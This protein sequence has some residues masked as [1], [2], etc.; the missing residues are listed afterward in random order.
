MDIIRDLEFFVISLQPVSETQMTSRK[1][2]DLCQKFYEVGKSYIEEQIRSHPMENVV[3]PGAAHRQGS[4]FNAFD[5]M[6]EFFQAS[7]AYSSTGDEFHHNMFTGDSAWLFGD[8][9]I[10]GV[11]DGGAFDLIE[12]TGPGF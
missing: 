4:T 8:P 3:A 2:H 9:H 11:M 10:L 6:P 5:L 1:M 12:K 7:E